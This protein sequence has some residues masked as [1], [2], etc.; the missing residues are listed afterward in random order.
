[1][2]VD[3]DVILYCD[4]GH[5]KVLPES[6]WLDLKAEHGPM[7]MCRRCDDKESLLPVD[8]IP[9]QHL[10]QILAKADQV[11]AQEAQE[12]AHF[13]EAYKRKPTP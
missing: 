13:K 8:Q 9:R 5:K 1:M 10:D 12:N 11:E 7:M 4:N 2:P 6:Y 3:K